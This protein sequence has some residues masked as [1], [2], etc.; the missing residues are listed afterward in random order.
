VV[1]VDVGELRYHS[2]TQRS[3]KRN[4]NRQNRLVKEY[5][6]IKMGIVP[7]IEREAEVGVY[8][9]EKGRCTSGS[10]KRPLYER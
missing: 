5:D 9:W 6:R 7:P 3:V 10:G 4:W 2:T 1:C 8:V